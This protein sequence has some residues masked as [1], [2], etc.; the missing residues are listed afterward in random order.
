MANSRSALGKGG[1]VAIWSSHYASSHI[2]GEG[3]RRIAHVFSGNSL[4]ILCSP[5]HSDLVGVQ[6][7]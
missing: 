3:M 1:P 7:D 5:V 4:V 2:A 6:N